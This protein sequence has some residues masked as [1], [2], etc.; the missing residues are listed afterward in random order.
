MYNIHSM[1]KRVPVQ[2]S[3]GHLKHSLAQVE[4]TLPWKKV[5]I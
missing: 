4:D 1:G 5:E 2:L 3:N